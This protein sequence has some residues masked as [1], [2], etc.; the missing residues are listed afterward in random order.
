MELL[1]VFCLKAMKNDT[2]FGFLQTSLLLLT[3][4]KLVADSFPVNSGLLKKVSE[5]ERKCH[6]N[7][8][9]DGCRDDKEAL[10]KEEKVDLDQAG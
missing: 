10:L 6:V 8:T 1:N 2:Q 9:T 3:I 7:E 5:P 4:D